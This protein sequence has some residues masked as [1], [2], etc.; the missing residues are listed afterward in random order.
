VSEQHADTGIQRYRNAPGVEKKMPIVGAGK[1][2]KSGM[3]GVMRSEFRQAGV[4]KQ[5]PEVAGREERRAPE[6]G[7]QR[8]DAPAALLAYFDRLAARLRRVRILCGDWR[9]VVKPSITINHGLTA[10]FMDPPYPQA[11]HDMGYH[12]DNN[13]WHAAAAWAVENDDNP[14]LRIAICGYWSEATDALFPVT[15]ERYRWEARG[16]YSNQSK[17]GRGRSNAKREC[18]WFSPHCIDAKADYGPLFEGFD[19]APPAAAPRCVAQ[20]DEVAA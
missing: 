2:G 12:G 1:R 4:P 3:N 8:Y 7:I 15:W 10:L 9:R 6:K 19:A 18:L 16:G 20:A 13:I 17:D 14:L 11:E 5:M